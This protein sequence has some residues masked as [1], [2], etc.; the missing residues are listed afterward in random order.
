[1]NPA[2]YKQPALARLHEIVQLHDTAQRIGAFSDWLRDWVEMPG[3][4][5]GSDKDALNWI[6]KDQFE[7]AHKARERAA[8]RELTAQLDNPAT[9]NREEKDKENALVT[10][11]TACVLRWRPR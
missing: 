1:M 10:T 3:A 4:Y 5:A 11:Y 9:L 7:F 2:I 6:R 8:F